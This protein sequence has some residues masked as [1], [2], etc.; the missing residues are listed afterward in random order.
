MIEIVFCDGKLMA[1]GKRVLCS[2]IFESLFKRV[3]Y[4]HDWIFPQNHTK[5]REKQTRRETTTKLSTY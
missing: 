5:F 2:E 3:L 4:E 1:G